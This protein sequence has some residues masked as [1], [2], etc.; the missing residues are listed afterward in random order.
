[1]KPKLVISVDFDGALCPQKFCRLDRGADPALVSALNALGAV[2]AKILCHS[3]MRAQGKDAVCAELVALGIKLEY[4]HEEVITDAV[5]TRW[6]SIENWYDRQLNANTDLE[7]IVI[8]D[9]PP[10]SK[11]RRWLRETFYNVN[12]ITTD[13]DV[14]IT[15]HQLMYLWLHPL[16]N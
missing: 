1:M 10:D 8:D 5:S 4:I 11:F 6:C 7:L 9:E 14:G 16:L 3:T 12:V 13:A 2:G 15:K